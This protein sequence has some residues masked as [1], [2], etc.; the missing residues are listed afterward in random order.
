MRPAAFQTL[1]G[2]FH[3]GIRASQKLLA[4][5]FVRTRIHKDLKAWIEACLGCQRNKVQQHNKAPI[6]TFPT[7]DARFS[8]LHLYI[9]GPLPLSNGCSYLLTCVDGT[10]NFRIQRGTRE[11]VV[12]VDRLKTAVPDTPTDEPCGPLLA[13]SP[14][15]SIPPSHILPLS[16]SPQPPT[17]TT[18]SSTFNTVIANHTLRLCPRHISPV[19]DAMFIFLTILLLMLFRHKQFLRRRYA[20]PSV[21][22]VGGTVAVR[23]SLLSAFVTLPLSPSLSASLPVDSLMGRA[24]SEY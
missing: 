14:L 12:G 16:P 6:S 11:E 20:P 8:H 10:K 4:E 13:P 7:P 3:P 15:R 2:L 18:P 22:P 21:W 19:A 1:H 23:V 9:V 17:S 24:P 5:R